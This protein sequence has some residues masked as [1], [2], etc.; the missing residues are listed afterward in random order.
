VALEKLYASQIVTWQPPLAQRAFAVLAAGSTTDNMG[1]GGTSTDGVRYGYFILNTA[2]WAIEEG[3]HT[4]PVTPGEQF[5]LYTAYNSTAAGSFKNPPAF[6]SGTVKWS[7]S[8]ANSSGGAPDLFAVQALTYAGLSA[9]GYSSV[10]GGAQTAALAAQAAATVAFN[11][12][13]ASGQTN[14]GSFNGAA[15][16]AQ[17]AQQ[18]AQTA[19]AAAA[20]NAFNTN[21][22][23]DWNASSTAYFNL[24]V[25]CTAVAAIA[26]SLGL[27]TVATNY[28]TAATDATTASNDAANAANSSTGSA[29]R[30]GLPIGSAPLWTLKDPTLCTIA[31]VQ[32]SGSG[33][34]YVYYTPNLASFNTV[35]TGVDGIITVPKPF[36]PRYLGQI[37]H[38]SATNYTWSIPGGPDQLTANLMVEP[39]YRTDALNPGRIVTVHRGSSCIWEGQ[40]TEPVPT[41]TG[42][43]LLCNGVGTYG[44]NF[45]AWWDLNL[46]K[47]AGWTTDAPVDLAVSRGLRWTNRGIGN[48]AGIYI[49]PVQDPGSLTVTD[50]LNLL[51]TGG[52]LT[53]ELVQPAGASSFP[54]A[55]WELSIYPLP[56]DLSGNPLNTG[57]TTKVQTSLNLSPGYLSRWKRTDLSGA[58]VRRPPDLYLINTSPVGRTI[59]ADYNTIIVYYEVAPDKTAKSTTT[60]A[61]AV[62]N[63][64]FADAPGSVSAHGRMEFFLDISNGG[65]MTQAQAYAIGQNVLSKYIRANFTSSFVVMPGQLINAGGVPVDLGCN[66]AGAMCTV[67][68]MNEAY[69]GEVGLAPL[70][71]LI[72]QYQFD[73]DTQ[74]AQ[75]TPYQNARTDM[76]SVISALYPGKFS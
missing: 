19:G 24:S 74:T 37:G 48:P 18:T 6:D 29:S 42:W 53:W 11:A 63:T 26:T 7:N 43:Q 73:D 9:S 30:D 40:L 12:Y 25:F 58:Y 31:N 75:V 21:A 54:P 47:G 16:T 22:L 65:A 66:W 70:T 41:T 45:G 76:S 62:F 20:A 59:I 69:G 3:N 14:N 28:T 2:Q 55:P 49:G 72:G 13:K 32:Q 64:T 8:S 61:T 36:N 71:F 44:S 46:P 4:P 50:F 60:A 52:A 68:G 1:A 23:G 27:T 67:Q 39:W 5:Q 38:V 15:L 33:A 51:C 34:W 10:W 35:V 56:S 17:A 57:P